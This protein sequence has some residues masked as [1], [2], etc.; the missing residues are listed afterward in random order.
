V[1]KLMYGAAM[2]A[3]LAVMGCGNST[4]RSAEIYM[5]Q[6]DGV[7]ARRIINEGLPTIPNGSVKAEAYSMLAH[8]TSEELMVLENQAKKANDEKDKES[9]F[10]KREEKIRQFNNEVNSSLQNGTEFSGTLDTLKENLWVDYFNSGVVWFN[11]TNQQNA[12]K[13]WSNAV[14]SFRL[15]WELDSVKHPM[16]ASLIGQAELQQSNHQVSA[17][18]W[19]KRAISNEIKDTPDYITRFNLANYYYTDTLWND[20]VN[21]Y[22]QV[23]LL[24]EPKPDA[25][26]NPKDS[27]QARIYKKR[28]EDFKIK[29]TM[30]IANKAIALTQLGRNP[31][32]MEAYALALKEDPNNS[33]LVYNLGQMYFNDALKDTT[34]GAAAKYSKAEELFNR[35][36]AIDSTDND[37]R[38]LLGMT[39]FQEEKFVDAERILREYLKSN[40]KKTEALLM[41]S[42]AIGNQ[43]N[44]LGESKGHE[45]EKKALS[46]RLTEIQDEIKKTGASG[47]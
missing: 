47:K 6:N 23:I 46:L 26:Y 1:K 28:Q 5:Q 38:Y 12:A 16:S 17:V 36:L 35:V 7:N 39:M 14:L 25:R 33:V 4:I 21:Y 41:I 40:P 27:I 18:N 9:Y 22:N 13:K 45:A 29:R 15:A 2:L 19:M 30:S 20:A 24:P 44:A 8:I 31:E 11:D 37:A 3:L 42:A 10:E 34:K 43:I 32:A